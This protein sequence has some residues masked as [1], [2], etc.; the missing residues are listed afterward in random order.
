[1]GEGPAGEGGRGLLCAALRVC[2]VARRGSQGFLHWRVPPRRLCGP[3]G[4]E[5]G[6]VRE[7]CCQDGRRHLGPV[8]GAS[9]PL[10]GG[11]YAGEGL[12]ARGPKSGIGS[13]LETV[14]F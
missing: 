12:G 1:M 7:D 6:G 2:G 9:L 8:P 11:L 3:L 5:G 13:V 14:L 10:M 4:R